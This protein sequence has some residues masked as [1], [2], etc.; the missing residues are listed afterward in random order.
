MGYCCYFGFCCCFRLP[1][2]FRRCCYFWDPTLFSTVPPFWDR[3]ISLLSSLFS[4]LSLLLASQ[5]AL[6]TGHFE[7]LIKPPNPLPTASPCA[8]P[9]L[10]PHHPCVTIP[11]LAAV[12]S[13]LLFSSLSL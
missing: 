13:S 1:C 7:L 8:S 5:I 9:S 4:L 6:R 2:C 11:G 10:C 12:F 3:T